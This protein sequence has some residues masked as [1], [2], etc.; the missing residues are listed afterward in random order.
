MNDIIALQCGHVLLR[1]VDTPV[2]D[3]ETGQQIGSMLAT[4]CIECDAILDEHRE[5]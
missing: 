1:F 4:Q 5:W 2:Y 3:D